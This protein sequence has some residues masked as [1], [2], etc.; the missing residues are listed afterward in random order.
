MTEPL[1]RYERR[2]AVAVLTLNRPD[3]PNAINVAM[4]GELTRA[5]DAAEADDAV[6]VVMVA[7]AG[8]A[9][10]AGFDLDM[11]TGGPPDGAAVRRALENDF[12]LIMRFW[13]SP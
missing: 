8:K 12:G 2:G 13:D 6:R 7:G 4:I 10:S 11:E 9:F 1:V 5:L 3:K